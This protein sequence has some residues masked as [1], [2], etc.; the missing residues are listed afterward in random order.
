M[1]LSFTK[2]VRAHRTFDHRRSRGDAMQQPNI[3]DQPQ[4][5]L[6]AFVDELADDATSLKACSLVSRH[7]FW[8]SRKH[9]FKRVC[10]SSVGGSRSLWNW[11]AVMNPRGTIFIQVQFPMA[12]RD[13]PRHPH[14]FYDIPSYITTRG[15]VDESSDAGPILC[16]L[17]I[18]RQG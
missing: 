2:P 8:R 11:S 18:I 12:H 16:P 10:F 5:I 4:E 17:S 14:H 7:W 6:D 9:L 15:S 13:N 1:C 3:N